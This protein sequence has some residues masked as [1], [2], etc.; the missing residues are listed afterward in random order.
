MK[1]KEGS[2]TIDL[3]T[4]TADEGYELDVTDGYDLAL[5]TNEGVTL[6]NCCRGVED[7]EDICLECH[8]AVFA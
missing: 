5:A 3:T 6:G 4:T 7:I 2:M 8:L 1:P